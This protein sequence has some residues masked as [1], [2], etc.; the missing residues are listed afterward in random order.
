MAQQSIFEGFDPQIEV[1]ENWSD[2]KE[3]S[4]LEEVSCQ[5]K[6]TA[7]NHLPL[8]LSLETG[9]QVHSLGGG[10]HIEKRLEVLQGKIDQILVASYDRVMHACV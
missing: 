6:Q 3:V 10:K 8:H 5:A 9:G 2:L 1:L 7:N 4:A